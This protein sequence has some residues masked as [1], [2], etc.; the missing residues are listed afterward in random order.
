M[1]CLIQSEPIA[2]IVSNS[3][4]ISLRFNAYAKQVGT[5]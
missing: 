4:L 1:L 3:T 5:Y 2:G